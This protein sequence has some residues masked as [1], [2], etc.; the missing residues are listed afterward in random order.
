[1]NT[2]ILRYQ[3]T[4]RLRYARNGINSGS[5]SQLS[6]QNKIQLLP[7]YTVRWKEAYF[8]LCPR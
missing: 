4:H 2:L 6:I 8:Y 7:D 1:M 5:Q 3:L